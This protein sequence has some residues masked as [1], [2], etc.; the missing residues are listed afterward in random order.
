MN[1]W[2][3]ILIAG[4]GSYLL[5]LSMIGTDR[6]RLPARLDDAATLVAPS[7]FTAL[8]VTSVA[9]AALAAGTPGFATPI[10][11]AAVAVAAVA[12]TGSPHVG[13]LTGMPTLWILT[14]VMA[15]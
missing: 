12:R 7:A 6:I 3:T 11:A 13:I 1:V 14:A 5:R 8:A 2:L 15:S 10:V 4:L 9:S